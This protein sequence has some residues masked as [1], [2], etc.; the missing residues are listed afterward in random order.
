[1]ASL[2]ELLVK[3]GADISEFS[4]QMSQVDKTMTSTGKGLMQTGKSVSAVGQSMA[5]SITAPLV[6]LGTTAVVTGA[7]FDAQMSKVSAV[8]GATG[9]DFE[10]LRDQA[11]EL[12]ASTVWSATEAGEG[13]EFLARAGWKT[14]QIM[15][16]M[17]NVLNLATASA[18]DLGTASDIA[19]NI[20]S[21][22]GATA[23]ESQRYID[24]LA[25]TTASS[26][27]DMLQLGDA[28][29]Y[30]APVANALGWSVEETASAIGRMSD[31]GIQGSQAGTSLRAGLLRIAKPTKMAKQAMDELGIAFFDAQGNLKD[32]PVIIGELEK[33]TAGM[34]TEQKT[35]TLAMLF[36]QEAVSGWLAL[37]DVGAENLGEFTSTLEN[38]DGTAQ[39]MADTMADNLAGSFKGLLSALEGVAISFSDVMS[40]AIRKATDW[41]TGMTRKFEE[42][43]PKTK[44]VIVIV[45]LLVAS[46]APLLIVIGLVAQGVGAMMVAFGAISAPVLA[47]V[48]VIG[49][50]V[51]IFRDELGGLFKTAMSWVQPVIDAFKYLNGGFNDSIFEAQKFGAG[52]EEV[53]GTKAYKVATILSQMKT[54]IMTIWNAV[55]DAVTPIVQTLVEIIKTIFN[56]L[57]AFWDEHG[58][59]MLEKIQS[60]WSG[61]MGIVQPLLQDIVAFVKEKLDMIK[62][63]WDENGTMIMEAVMNVWN[64]I[65]GVIEFVMPVIEFIIKTVWESIKGIISGVLNVI[66]GLVKVFAGL[67]TGDFSKMWEGVKQLFFGAI[68][69]VWNYLN[70]M[71]IGRIVKGIGA[72]IKGI[73][74]SI[75]T[76]GTN[77]INSFKSTWDNIW[78]GIS[79]FVSNG[80]EKI[81]YFQRIGAN[82]FQAVKTTIT[83]AIQGAKTKALSLIEGLKTGA[84]NTFNNLKSTVQT[85][86]NKVRDFIKN[87]IEEG[88]KIV[89]GIIDDI[90]GA[91][92]KMKITIPKPKLP[93]ISVSMKTGVMGIPYPD[94]DIKWNAKGAIFNGATVLGGGQGVGE[95]GAEA[96][97]PIQHKRYM[98]P[99]ARAVAEQLPQP[100]SQRE[101]I[102]ENYHTT[103]IE[104]DGQ[105][106]GR[107]VEKYVSRE[108]LNRQKRTN[109]GGRR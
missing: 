22:F 11:K 67:F 49:L 13:M 68:E 8:S 43:S 57:K 86:F 109:K 98:A 77:L 34:T 48:G 105:E 10:K 78:N 38:A 85:V 80:I 15:S 16:A 52:V 90:V 74:S 75:K 33:A 45:G 3:V 97:L 26:N 36:G 30:V 76:F 18:I 62:Q 87:P 51:Y 46:I 4:R 79:K 94:F 58:A 20:I 72:F 35:A 19:S 56:D 102:V 91:F 103:V 66:M 28:M 54:K 23:D 53:I 40:P 100:N 44:G 37:I 93:K 82:I 81:N 39:Q 92:S 95:A 41:L 83:E 14:E 69:A 108:Q 47:I 31:A 12:G 25:K 70:L 9:K 107:K 50:L 89:L 60:V 64:F 101:V 2:A 96:V 99:F 73:V 84:V 1:M 17:P 106:V 55:K 104:L 5:M 65:L 88:K 21:G 61:I 32:M 59:S 6:A 29:K 24:V 42:L 71:F 63:F 7:K 27:T